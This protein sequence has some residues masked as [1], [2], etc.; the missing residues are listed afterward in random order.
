MIC[1]ECKSN[2]A[3]MFYQ[4][5]I[6]GK[7]SELALCKDCAAK[8][9][10]ISGTSLF[11]DLFNIPFIKTARSEENH[12]VC[13]L[14]GKDEKSFIKDG[15]VS[16]PVCYETFADELS[17]PIKRIHG[18]VSHIG[19][20]PSKFKRQND[21]KK[22]LADLKKQLEEAIKGEEYENAAVLRDKIRGIENAAD[23]E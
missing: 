22:V 5:T 23:G 16:C 18:N 11:S 3:T 21:K 17:V 1:S 8:H 2:N 7:T 20:A 12:K 10:I 14:C 6:N 19:R 4:Q 13:S 15:K 9:G